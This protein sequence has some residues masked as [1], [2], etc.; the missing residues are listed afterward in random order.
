MAAKRT[1]LEFSLI[2]SVSRVLRGIGTGVSNTL[3]QFA[4]LNQTVELFDKTLSGLSTGFGLGPALGEIGALEDILTRVSTLTQATA[5]EQVAL[6]AAVTAASQATRFS[7]EEA[8]A[9]LAALAEDGLSATEAARELGNVLAFA[10]AN[11]QTATQAA[12]GL[13]AVLDT[14]GAQASQIGTVADQLTAV[15]Q[16]S[17]TSTRALQEGL[18]AAGV[19]AD[20]AGLSIQTTV[21]AL[22][23]LAQGGIDGGA[24]G[25]TLTKILQELSDPASKAGEALQKLGLEGRS[26]SDVLAILSRDSNAAQE[27]L[28]ALG[29]KPRAALQLLLKDGGSAIQGLSKVIRESGGAADTAA[30]KLNETYSGALDR[31]GNSLVAVRNSLLTPLLKPLATEFDEL[32]KKIDAFIESDAFGTLKTKLTEF[33]RDGIDK[34]SEFVKTVSFEDITDAVTSFASAASEAVQDLAYVIKQAAE[35]VRFF[36]SIPSTVADAVNDIAGAAAANQKFADA[37]KK[38]REEQQATVSSS[39]AAGTAVRG[40][41]T[42]A[43]EVSKALELIG[44][45]AD[46]AANAVTSSA[47]RQTRALNGASEAG[48]KQILTLKQIEEAANKARD[49]KLKQFADEEKAAQ[50]EALQREQALKAK[51]EAE[52]ADRRRAAAARDV[53]DATREGARATEDAGNAAQ[54]AA[55]EEEKLNQAYAQRKIELGEVSKAF[56]TSI[57]EIFQTLGGGGRIFNLYTKGF[58]DLTNELGRQ[59]TAVQEQIR[60]IREQTA[61]YDPLAKEMKRLAGIYPFVGEAALRTLAQEKL[62]LKELR[63]QAKETERIIRQVSSG[64]GG[65]NAQGG[66]GGNPQGNAGG[67]PQ[68]RAGGSYGQQAAPAPA[69]APAPSGSGS[70]EIIEVRISGTDG[71][72]SLDERAADALARRL[73]APLRRL[74]ASGAPI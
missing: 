73:A 60:L 69:P 10:Q 56:Q 41:G 26:F 40:I 53:A 36:A 67:N 16:A 52:E 35:L 12:E 66:G 70:R 38:V 6:Q 47:D 3:N 23:A 44:P 14:F 46:G 65:G 50:D 62:R 42:A 2:D 17:G 39:N 32:K 19:A 18:A 59:N 15:A 20:Q 33:V 11:A 54:K 74:R 7:A 27:V 5:E 37:L 22:G 49:A 57:Q 13:G 31:L 8:A 48:A 30:Q 29:D 51:L 58:S 28:Q 55:T 71:L 21:T 72:V 24:A 4:N 43:G 9:G 64:V 63:D 34:F 25:K 45:A 68:G 61:E 1:E